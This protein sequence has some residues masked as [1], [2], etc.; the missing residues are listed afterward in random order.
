MTRRHS[1]ARTALSVAVLLGSLGMVTWRQSRALET[2]ARLEGIR[3]QISVAEADRV[4]LERRIQVLE[5]R[6]RVVPTARE[7]LGMHTATT[8]ELVILPGDITP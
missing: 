7:R 6:T 4:D 5:S 1:F 2:L 3:R 8:S